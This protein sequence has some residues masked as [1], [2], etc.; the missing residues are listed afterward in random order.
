MS[1]SPIALENIDKDRARRHKEKFKGVGE[2][3]VSVHLEEVVKTIFVNETR[4]NIKIF[5]RKMKKQDLGLAKKVLK[6]VAWLKMLCKWLCDDASGTLDNEL[7]RKGGADDDDTT[8]QD[9]RELECQP[10]H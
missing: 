3:S 5:V 1:Y 4:K 8:I 10:S 6:T 9:G 2:I 7:F